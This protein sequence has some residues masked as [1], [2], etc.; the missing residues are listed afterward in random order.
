MYRQRG[1]HPLKTIELHSGWDLCLN[2]RPNTQKV[3]GEWKNG[4]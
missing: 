2:T 1:K 3:K 4:R